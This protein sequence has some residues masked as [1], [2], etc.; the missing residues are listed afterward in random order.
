MTEIPHANQEAPL[1]STREELGAVAL[2]GLSQSEEPQAEG[3]DI[4]DGPPAESEPSQYDSARITKM[5]FESFRVSQGSVDMQQQLLRFVGERHAAQLRGFSEDDLDEVLFEDVHTSLIDS[6]TRYITRGSAHRRI[7][8]EYIDQNKQRL[9]KNTPE[10]FIEYQVLNTLFMLK[11]GVDNDDTGN[12]FDAIRTLDTMIDLDASFLRPTAERDGRPRPGARRD[13]HED[14][15]AVENSHHASQLVLHGLIGQPTRVPEFDEFFEE[16]AAQLP[17]FL[18]DIESEHAE[19]AQQLH[20]IIEQHLQHY[21][22]DAD[23]IQPQYRELL[24]R[25]WGEAEARRLGLIA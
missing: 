6:T 13:P 11:E 19:A 15:K 9:E 3:L 21:P 8:Q 17:A 22:A 24:T 10:E 5:L 23:R 20:I 7:D 12:R 25:H 2:H 1:T 14:G 4:S 16:V 18:E